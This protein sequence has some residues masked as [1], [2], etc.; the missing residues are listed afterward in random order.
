MVMAGSKPNGGWIIGWQRWSNLN[1]F[2]VFTL[3][4][5]A[6]RWRGAAANNW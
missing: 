6:P 1:G 2:G 3:W 5:S 4:P